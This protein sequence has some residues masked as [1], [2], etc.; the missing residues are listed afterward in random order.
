M[1]YFLPSFFQKRVLRYVLSRLDI[2][3]ASALDLEQLDIS[4]G[5]KS[6]FDF[7]DVGL[8]LEVRHGLQ[9]RAERFPTPCLSWLLLTVFQRLT[10]LLSLPP[11]F[12]VHDA[13]VRSLRIT[14]PSD[15]Y[16]SGISIDIGGV[17]VKSVLKRHE[18]TDQSRSPWQK[19]KAGISGLAKG[20]KANRPRDIR[21]RHYD[22]G[23]GH[24]LRGSSAS[25]LPTTEDLAKS[26]LGAEPPE[27]KAQLRT[28]IAKSQRL[29][30]SQISDDG[31]ETAE[32]GFGTV[33]SLP[34][35]VAD[36]ISGV[37]SRLTVIVKDVEIGVVA[38][39]PGQGARMD[40]LA[41][42]TFVEEIRVQEVKDRPRKDS[43]GEDGSRDQEAG[44]RR[45]IKIKGVRGCLLTEETVFSLF[46]QPSEANSPVLSQ[47]AAQGKR[48]RDMASSTPHR[49]A[50][51]SLKPRMANLVAT[52]TG[53]ESTG[54]FTRSLHAANL[55]PHVDFREGQAENLELSQDS[56]LV[57]RSADDPGDSRYEDWEASSQIIPSRHD[58]SPES[59][60][61][62]SMS[63]EVTEN[64]QN[65]S[66]DDGRQHVLHDDRVITSARTSLPGTFE[67]DAKSTQSSPEVYSAAS[68]VSDVQARSYHTS[69][70]EDLTQSK[71]FTHE[72]AESMYMSATSNAMEPPEENLVPGSWIADQVDEDRPTEISSKHKQDAD[73]P[74]LAPALVRPVA[75]ESS[76]ISS[77]HNSAASNKARTKKES[78]LPRAHSHQGASGR[79]ANSTAKKGEVVEQQVPSTSKS[80]EGASDYSPA[81]SRTQKTLFTADAIE[82]R[83]PAFQSQS[84]SAHDSRSPEDDGSGAM[85]GTYS[86]TSTLMQSESPPSPR[87]SLSTRSATN[88]EAEDNQAISIQ[89]DVIRVFTDMALLRIAA[90]VLELVPRSPQKPDRDPVSQDMD[91]PSLYTPVDFAIGLF[92]FDF[93]DNLRGEAEGPRNDETRV[94]EQSLNEVLL[95]LEAIQC[96]A[97]RKCDASNRETIISLGRLSFGYVD[98]P[99]LS[100][101]SSLRMRESVRDTLEPT[102][103]DVTITISEKSRK[104]LD[105]TMMTLPMYLQLD[106]G[107]VDETL[108][109]LGGLSGVLGLG[110]SVMSTITVTDAK[111]SISQSPRAKQAVR[112]DTNPTVLEEPAMDNQP[113]F[114]ARIGGATIN[115]CGKEC[116]VALES[117]ALK[118]V[119]RA[120]G[121]GLRI[122]KSRL[123][124]PVLPQ[125]NA[126][127][128]IMAR[129][130]NVRLEYLPTP[131]EEDLGR[132]LALL[133]PSRDPQAQ[134][135]EILLDTLLRQ[136]RQGGLIRLNLANVSGELT[137]LH[138]LE[139]LQTLTEEMKKL[140][141]VAKYLPED[142]RPGIL[143]LALVQE[144]SID[145]ELSTDIGRAT[146]STRN[147]ELGHV[148]IPSLVVLGVDE[149]VVRHGG[150]DLVGAAVP[151][152]GEPA[153]GP[154]RSIMARLIGDEVEPTL[155]VKL[156]N[157]R[158]EYYVTTI[159]GFLGIKDGT[160]SEVL[161]AELAGSV[162]TVLM[163]KAAPKQAIQAS[164]HSSKASDTWPGKIELQVGDSLIGLNPRGSPAKG[165]VLLNNGVLTAD[166]PKVG[167]AE[168]SAKLEIRKMA[169]L[170][171]DDVTNIH[172]AGTLQSPS[173]P[174]EPA[175][176]ADPT[177]HLWSIG[178]VTVCEIS[179][180]SVVA[181]AVPSGKDGQQLVDVE[182]HDDLLVLETCA[183]S[184]QTLQ[185]ILSGL[186]PPSPPSKELKYRTEVVP[187]QDMLASF[188]GDAFETDAQEEDDTDYSV[189]QRLGDEDMVED[190]VPQNLEFVSSFYDPD[191]ESTAKSVENSML[192]SELSSL[193][194][195]PETRERGGKP[196]L[197]SFH[198][199]YEVEPEGE[200]LR[201]EDDH[202]GNSSTVGGTA[203]RWNS[204]GNTYDIANESKIRT[205]PLKVRVR[206]INFI[207]N[208]FDGYDWQSTRDTISDAVADLES[209][210]EQRRA[211]QRERR[212][213]R[214]LDDEDEPVIGDFLF[215][216]IYIGIPANHDPRDLARQVNRNLDDL[217]SETE[218]YATTTTASPSPSRQGAPKTRKRRLRLRRSKHQKMTIELR[219]LSADAIVFPPD[220]GETQ[221]SVDIRVQ[222]LEIFDHVPTSTWKKFAT[223]M[224]DM[225]ERESGTSMVHIEMVT[226]RPVPDLAASEIILKLSVLPL[227]L[228]VDQDALDFLTRFFEFREAG[229]PVAPTPRTEIPFL[230]R[231]EVH[232]IPIRL[233]FKP[234]RVDYAGL[235]SGRTTEFMNFFVLEAADMVLRHVIV[236]GVS[237][238]DRLGHT[239]NDIWMP[240]VRRNQLPMVLA[241]LAAVRPLVNVGAG[242]R[243]LV[244]VPVREYR[245]DGRMVRAIQKGAVAFA[246][247]TTT[248]L[249]RLGAK[250]AVGTQTVLQNAEGLLAPE[251]A[252]G[253]AP[254]T[255]A[256]L[257]AVGAAGD[258]P[259]EERPIISPYADQPVGVVQGLRGAYR[260]LERDLLLAKDAIVAMPG[261]V[262]ESGTAGEAARAVL[263]GAPTVILRPALGV[264]KA[265][266]QTL[267]GAT[268]TLDRGERRRVEDV[269]GSSVPFFIHYIC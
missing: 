36:F 86:A 60:L 143:T 103:H 205:S 77:D 218:S 44:G 268:N 153:R 212:K 113:R 57:A 230:Q 13:R 53:T 193:A 105:V 185:A 30:Q 209:R 107:C 46:A 88:D 264:T 22:P 33:L 260:H 47:D 251:G 115:L 141:G 214:D 262:L 180:A 220:T 233:D 241:G 197:T 69:G 210:A 112:F 9:P 121:L 56:L 137:Q 127:P 265:V 83:L 63:S 114:T 239:L 16:S 10:T 227:R 129:V 90:A 259:P 91:L 195:G 161:A 35:F 224:H 169:L 163:P 133:S 172:S 55:R 68:S 134:D 154:G 70:P 229:T 173:D 263:R 255:P 155:K 4:W 261:E 178:Y 247:T 243:D 58:G 267:L 11:Y 245:K 122:D 130:D 186:S 95:S 217:A 3:D 166:W 140:A 38:Q 174:L 45:G 19:R 87:K 31:E 101:D 226:V 170:L 97:S 206:D 54:T 74:T 49:T 215:N 6:T 96:Q 131:K 269:S 117:T 237:G 256:V 235:R 67:N 258:E 135:D 257:D 150:K 225:G 200:S 144:C 187:V 146:I 159:M 202:F 7:R 111:P 244:A 175:V 37:V 162:S 242:V 98:Q 164:S 249:A 21:S 40:E 148:S 248:E 139:H 189:S 253:M 158:A 136:R 118:F 167:D 240:D 18:E 108:N 29:D 59:G 168:I 165:M 184:T 116:S 123:R 198:E 52:S 25:G 71:L 204:D 75:Q 42:K 34:S 201:F 183:D 157:V 1:A 234:K 221:S 66:L 176:K 149:V 39:L 106:L 145:I 228:H 26:Y 79:S 24:D 152:Q 99:L 43:S 89:L 62:R 65:F 72:E 196:T 192:E 78:P 219:G 147:T 119:S 81:A 128:A 84:K 250:L 124:G 156:W 126:D 5:K 223:Y 236:Y 80:E 211:A 15:I 266:G 181:R 213:S 51:P 8:Q 151:H 41:V 182:V 238:F 28:A 246:R 61:Y 232:A 188:T 27:E 50:M 252:G 102:G 216:S 12:E 48:D 20:V 171:I 92:K 191:P 222:D 100:F 208:M 110:S 194:S 203:H 23:G 17:V 64:R 14:I 120:E 104:P 109:W 142:D 73:T 125:S 76:S 179:A 82:L 190:E 231:A 138:E 2:I 207:W 94:A 85:P 199:Q 32:E 93:V 254:T 160:T 132:L 177:R